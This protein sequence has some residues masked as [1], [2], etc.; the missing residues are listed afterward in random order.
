M[1][2][3]RSER[4]QAATGREAAVTR[5][6]AG[7]QTGAGVPPEGEKAARREERARNRGAPQRLSRYIL[8]ARWRAAHRTCRPPL[9]SGAPMTG[10]ECADRHGSERPQRTWTPHGFSGGTRGLAYARGRAKGMGAPSAILAA[11]RMASSEVAKWDKVTSAST[12]PF[13]VD[14]CDG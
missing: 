11:R 8:H 6:R 14:A 13:A 1:A 2:R 7:T 3:E 9:H 4:A 12:P 5:P 10:K